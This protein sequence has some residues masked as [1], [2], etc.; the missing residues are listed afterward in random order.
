MP[1]L[2]K[3]ASCPSRTISLQSSQVSSTPPSRTF[4]DDDGARWVVYEQALTE[5][6]RRNGGSLIFNSD[7]AVRRVRNFP[8]NWM[9]LSDAELT[10]LSWQA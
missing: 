9:A 8:E 10:K 5:Y 3:Y 1:L 4:I 2:V 7:F 6:D